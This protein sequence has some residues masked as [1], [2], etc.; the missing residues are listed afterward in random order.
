MLKKMLFEINI[1]RKWKSNFCLFNFL[2]FFFYNILFDFTN[3]SEF[4][5]K[6]FPII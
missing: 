4:S 6:L 5:F 3:F 2:I 1:Y